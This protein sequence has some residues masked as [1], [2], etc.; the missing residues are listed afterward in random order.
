MG[1]ILLECSLDVWISAE[2]FAYALHKHVEIVGCRLAIAVIAINRNMKAR[3]NR[4]VVLILINI[5]VFSKFN[6][7]NRN[8]LLLRFSIE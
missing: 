3:R 4:L 5:I 7:S 2:V 6:Y 1:I 8:G